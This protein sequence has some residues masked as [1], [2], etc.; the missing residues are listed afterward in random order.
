MRRYTY[1]STAH[2]RSHKPRRRI[3]VRPRFFLILTVF[4][5]LLSVAF[6][7]LADAQTHRMVGNKHIESS[8]GNTVTPI[9]NAT[10]DT[11]SGDGSAAGPDQTTEKNPADYGLYQRLLQSS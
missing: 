6:F 1:N 2:E 11:D 8:D 3:T 9:V 10:P 7:S 5:V 4:F